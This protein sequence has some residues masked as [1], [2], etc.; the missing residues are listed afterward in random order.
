MAGERM[1]SG[2]DFAGRA[3]LVLAALLCATASWAQTGVR[4][5]AFDMFMSEAIW[6]S[7]QLM[8]N[9]DFDEAQNYLNVEFFQQFS[10]F[11]DR[12]K[13][14]LV[15]QQARIQI[16]GNVVRHRPEQQQ[17][18]L[19]LL[20][21]ISDS[22]DAIRDKSIQARYLATLAWAQLHNSEVDLAEENFR[23]SLRLFE[24]TGDQK[25]AAGS[26]AFLVL[27]THNRLKREGDT[28]KLLAHIPAY[29]EEIAFSEASGNRM[30]LGYNLRHL[31]LI[32]LDQVEDFDRA[33]ELYE[34]SLAARGQIGFKPFMPA[35]YSSIGDVLR[36]KED[37]ERAIAVYQ[38]SIE[39]AD[40]ID[41]VRYRVHPRI[42]IGDIYQRMRNEAQ[43]Q[44]H[45]ERA[46]EVATASR[47]QAG[48]DEASARLSGDR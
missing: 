36:Q 14:A 16:I 20:L 41:F 38:R 19:Q 46:L 39:L 33:L 44:V 47:Y 25:G 5:E 43:A 32:Y 34:A 29:E 3:C 11:S 15:S 26:R 42:R 2:C 45:Y 18:V 10:T 9:A 23:E 22:A 35:S 12:H 13:A 30:A 48:M 8:F 6:R 31:A 1:N 4:E 21:S 17:K 24:E 27:I 40:E 7:E 37:Y 28:D